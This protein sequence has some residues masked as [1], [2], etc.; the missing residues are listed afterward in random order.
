MS[1]ENLPPEVEVNV[2]HYTHEERWQNFADVIM[3][4]LTMHATL[5]AGHISVMDAS[6][7]SDDPKA[8]LPSEQEYQQLLI[9]HATFDTSDPSAKYD[10]SSKHK[11]GIGGFAKVFRVIRRSDGLLCALKF[12]QCKNE[13]E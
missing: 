4:L 7:R 13:K 11:L 12:V 5:N 1:Y 9:D 8:S 10:I 6:H 3:C 2:Y